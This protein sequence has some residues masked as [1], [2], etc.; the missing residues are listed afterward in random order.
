MSTKIVSGADYLTLPRAPETWLVE[1]LIPAG[2]TCLLFGDP[3]VGKSY[4]AL[5]LTFALEA[6]SEWLGFPVR[7]N[8]RVVYVQLDTPR[9][10][11]AKRL[12]TLK[13]DGYPVET[14]SLADRETLDCYP[15]NILDPLHADTLQ[16]A[17]KE[18]N[19]IAVVV[20]TL[21]ESCTGA[22]KN[23]STAMQ[24]VL[25]NLTK[26]VSPAALII[27]SHSRKQNGEQGPDLIND[28]RGSSYMPGR[29]DAIIR[30]THKTV[31][32]T[33]RAIE[34]GSMR[35]QRM[36]NGLWVPDSA[37]IDKAVEMILLDPSLTTLRARARALAERVGK[38]EEA[39]RS[40]LRRV[41]KK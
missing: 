12:D 17:L 40:F 6:G 31:Y 36:D 20:D 1:P 15:F 41:G 14:L 4:A 26:V 37:E 35:L 10:L 11:W 16:Q 2:G 38:G 23:D 7:T 27:I 33:G 9:S 18:V 24:N 8:G 3:K 13:K 25:A 19:P 34:A 28:T 22:D 5:Q 39:C 32:Y 21:R 30:F 29:A